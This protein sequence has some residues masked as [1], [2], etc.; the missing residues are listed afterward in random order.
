MLVCAVAVLHGKLDRAHDCVGRPSAFYQDHDLGMFQA[1]VCGADALSSLYRGDW[2]HA[3]LVAEQILT[4]AKLPARQNPA[5]SPSPNTRHQ[6]RSLFHRRQHRQSR[7]KVT[8]RHPGAAVGVDTDMH[9]ALGEHLV[10]RPTPRRQVHE[11]RV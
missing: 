9:S 10:P 6:F 11:I 3:A 2:D 5:P 1:L 4:R 7:R 8:D